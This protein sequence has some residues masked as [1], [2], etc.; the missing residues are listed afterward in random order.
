MSRRLL[1]LTAAC[2]LAVGL[3]ACDNGPS[4]DPEADEDLIDDVILTVDDLPEGFEE[5]DVDNDD[6][7]LG[8]ECNE[9]VLGLDR[10][11]ID[12][13]TTAEPGPVQFDS[14]EASVRAEVTAFESDDEITR[15][16]EAIEDDDYVDCLGEALD[17]DA[18]AGVTVIDIDAIDSPFEDNDALVGAVRVV[19]EVNSPATAGV[20][21]EAESQQHAVV[22]DRFG[23][24]LQV[25]AEQGQIDDELVDDLL[26]T[27]V[28]RLQDGLEES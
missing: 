17:D 25:T 4:I 8:E 3:A 6:S 26:E 2:S 7:T 20:V 23:I 14:D 10:D 21:V 5:V 13:A 12:D 22:V 16:V 1:V 27:M 18:E 24:T 15:I 19:F 11:A 28:D 9:E